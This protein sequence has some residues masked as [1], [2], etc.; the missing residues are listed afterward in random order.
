MSDRLSE[1]AIERAV[2]REAATRLSRRSVDA[3]QKDEA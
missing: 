1:A 2:A 3:L